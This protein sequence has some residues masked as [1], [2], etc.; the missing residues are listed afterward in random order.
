[1]YSEARAEQQSVIIMTPLRTALAQRG[2]FSP[3]DEFSIGIEISGRLGPRG[4]AEVDRSGGQCATPGRRRTSSTSVRR[5]LRSAVSRWGRLAQASSSSASFERGLSSQ[6]ST[7]RASDAKKP[8]AKAA[9][10]P[11]FMAFTHTRS[12]CVISERPPVHRIRGAEAGKVKEIGPYHRK[13]TKCTGKVS[14]L[15]CRQTGSRN[16]HPSKATWPA[17]PHSRARV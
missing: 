9:T 3:K 10:T 16:A 1:M 11:D 13:A 5:W 8:E 7:G 14:P 15:G 4:P 6:L 2:Y 12:V 17:Q